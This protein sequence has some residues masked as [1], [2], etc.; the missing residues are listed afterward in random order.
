[1]NKIIL[2]LILLLLALNLSVQNSVAQTRIDISGCD[3]DRDSSEDKVQARRCSFSNPLQMTVCRR[4]V[5]R[6]SSAGFSRESR[7]VLRTRLSRLK[8]PTSLFTCDLG[9]LSN[10][11]SFD[12]SRYTNAQLTDNDEIWGAN[13]N[14]KVRKFR[15]LNRK[16][17]QGLSEVCRSTRALRSCE[18]WKARASGHIPGSDPRSSSTSFIALRG[19]PGTYSSCIPVYDKN[20]NKIHSLGEYPNSISSYDSRHYGG[21]GCGD[22]KSPSRVADEARANTGSP[23]VYVKDSDG[24]CVRVPNAG[25]CYNSSEC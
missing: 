10:M 23:E 20:G 22:G 12:V 16:A 17:P 9:S 5:V 19:C 11:P 15:N 25:V 2:T 13:K 18:I 4:V 21:S 1:M 24:V 14:L 8:K 6:L 7:Q 3:I